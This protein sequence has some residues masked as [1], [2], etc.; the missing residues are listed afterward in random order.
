M[1]RKPT[2][3]LSDEVYRGLH[4]RIGRGEISRFIEGFAR[5]LVLDDDLDAAYRDMAA[6][7]ARARGARMDRGATGRGAEG[8][9][10]RGR[11]LKPRLGGLRP[12]NPAG[13]GFP[14]SHP[15]R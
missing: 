15:L 2:I 9:A 12:R 10:K 7:V 8:T 5:P 14:F 11:R 4:E 13:A 6:D 3:T 1:R